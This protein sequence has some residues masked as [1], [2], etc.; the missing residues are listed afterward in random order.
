MAEPVLI[1]P[2]YTP[3]IARRPVRLH[4]RALARVRRADRIARRLGI[5]RI[6][7][8]GGA[9]HPEGTP[10]LEADEMA[11]ALNQL[12]WGGDSVIL[13]RAARHSYTNLRNAGRIMLDRGWETARVVTGRGHAL[14]MGFGRFSRFERRTLDALGYLPGTIRLVG[15]GQLIFCPVDDVRRPGTDPLDP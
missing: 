3:S 7:L 9:V 10:F 6:I 13:E 12:G 1:V 11:K 2:G 4:P 8:S 15:P 5:D 14:Y